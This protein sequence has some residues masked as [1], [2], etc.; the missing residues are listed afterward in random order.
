MQLNKYANLISVQY[1]RVMILQGHKTKHE[2][3]PK[4][5][6]HTKKWDTYTQASIKAQT[7]MQTYHQG[8]GLG[9]A[10]IHMLNH[11]NI[12][13]NKRYNEVVRLTKK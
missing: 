13:A 11:Q 2:V 1:P 10:K 12:D 7:H 5:K 3:I 4:R 6:N 9:C 8:I